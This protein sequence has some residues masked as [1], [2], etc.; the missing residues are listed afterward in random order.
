[1][2]S[3][4][5]ERS[6]SVISAL[7][8]NACPLL[9]SMP[10]PKKGTVPDCSSCGVFAGHLQDYGGIQHRAVQCRREPQVADTA[11]H[12]QHQRVMRRQTKST[13]VT[14]R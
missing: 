5:P 3:R 8:D 12:H 14:S 2:R 11:E 4:A 1:M 9:I 6:T 7:R 10:D 13:A